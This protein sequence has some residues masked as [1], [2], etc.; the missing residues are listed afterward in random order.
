MNNEAGLVSSCR[1]LIVSYMSQS[2]R[3]EGTHLCGHNNV[4]CLFACR[5]RKT[6]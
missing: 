4:M 1:M 2:L 5:K 6:S 3:S